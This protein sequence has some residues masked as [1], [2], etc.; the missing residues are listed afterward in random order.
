MG[1]RRGGEKLPDGDH[2]RPLD[3]GHP[4]DGDHPPCGTAGCASSSSGA[5]ACGASSPLP[6]LRL[7]EISTPLDSD[8]VDDDEGA[9]PH[10]IAEASSAEAAAE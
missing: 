6:R 7:L 4:P 3:R 8:T 1:G 5:A 2:K 10:P 9:S